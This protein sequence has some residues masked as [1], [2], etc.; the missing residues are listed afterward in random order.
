MQRLIVKRND[1]NIFELDPEKFKELFEVWR[2]ATVIDD[3]PIK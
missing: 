2:K 3:I 1:E